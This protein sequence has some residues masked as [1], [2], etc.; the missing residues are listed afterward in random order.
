LTEVVDNNTEA[1][2]ILY[3]KLD[4]EKRSIRGEEE[5]EEE[6]E[7]NAMQHDYNVRD[8]ILELTEKEE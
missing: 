6:E 3:Y 5:K 7:I 8:R 1:G 4:S 2:S